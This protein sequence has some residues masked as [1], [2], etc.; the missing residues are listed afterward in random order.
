MTRLSSGRAGT[1]AGPESPP[2]SI[3]SRLSSLRLDD[4]FFG[5]WQLTHFST[6]IG[7]ILASKNSAASGEIASAGF[8][9]PS[10]RAATSPPIPISIATA[11]NTRA[12]RRTGVRAACR[13]FSGPSLRK[14]CAMTRI[15]PGSC[16]SGNTGGGF[17][18]LAGWR[19][20]GAL[21]STGER[22]P[23]RIERSKSRSTIRHYRPPIAPG[24]PPTKSPVRQDCHALIGPGS[25]SESVPGVEF[26]DCQRR[27]GRS[28]RAPSVSIL[29]GMAGIL[30]IELFSSPRVIHEGRTQ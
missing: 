10:A 9:P 14:A 1:I 22:N 2:L 8:A 12:T 18:I 4:C 17:A 23:G 13:S 3:A 21:S 29:Q 25:R 26:P 24:Q 20:G 7:R 15:G 30:R 28:G 6:R 16:G 11:G 5:P 19:G 27:S